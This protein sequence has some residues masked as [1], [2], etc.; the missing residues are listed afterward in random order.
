[1]H[2]MRDNPSIPAWRSDEQ[3]SQ[4]APE[5]EPAYFDDALQAWVLSRHHDILAVLR[6]NCAVPASVKRGEAIAPA[7]EELRVRLRT[8]TLEV[9]SPALLRQ[10]RQALLPELNRLMQ[11]L[12]AGEPADVLAAYARPACLTLAAIVTGISQYQAETL[13][14]HARHVSASAANPYDD[15]L[16]AS[17]EASQARLQEGHF[18]AEC[19]ALRDST[20]VAI[21]QTIP[22]MLGN[23]WYALLR[24]PEQWL[25][26]HEHPELT[27]PAVE[28]L[29]RYAGL[30]RLIAREATAD[31]EINGSVIR[32]GQ[33]IILRIV[34]GNRDPQRFPDSHAVDVV[35]SAAG[36]LA[37]GA[38]AHSCVGASLIRMSLVT[39]TAPLLR[40][41]ST[42]TLARPVDWQG[43]AIFQSPQSLWID[44]SL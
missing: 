11:N 19:E 17:S 31:L 6:E 38:G 15:S 36:H 40:R 10:W 3:G 39:V 27:E 25:L 14:K 21:S 20:F 7:N 41:F 32:K 44:L 4:E 34:A 9:L 43:G 12:H 28:E 24:H 29:L 8:Q 26:L 2:A 23:A 30:T 42:A 18:H 33:R 37:L 13:C 35:R 5:L 16:R 22:C 1:M